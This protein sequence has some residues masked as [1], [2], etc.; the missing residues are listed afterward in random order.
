MLVCLYIVYIYV[1]TFLENTFRTKKGFGFD[2]LKQNEK[3]S[4]PTKKTK[5]NRANRY[6]YCIETKK[7]I[8]T[9]VFFSRGDTRELDHQT[10]PLFSRTFLFCLNTQYFQLNEL[11]NS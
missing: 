7:I 6:S 2:L 1:Q 11:Q 9:I 8:V 4:V 10:G 3:K 5:K